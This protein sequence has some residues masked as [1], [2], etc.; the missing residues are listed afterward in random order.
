MAVDDGAATRLRIPEPERR[1]RQFPHE[2]SGGML[3]RA[4]IAGASANRPR[5]LIADEPTASLDAYLAVDVVH[6]L[7]ERSAARGRGPCC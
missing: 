5:L 4:A 7:R 1:A 2:W 3:Q 6:G